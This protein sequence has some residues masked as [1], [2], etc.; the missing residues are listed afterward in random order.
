MMTLAIIGVWVLVVLFIAIVFACGVLVDR[1]LNTNKSEKWDTAVSI[2]ITLF[3][4]IPPFITY[5]IYYICL[6]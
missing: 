3:F 4:A 5:A 1:M 6:K 2:V